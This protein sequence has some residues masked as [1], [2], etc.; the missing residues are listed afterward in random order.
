M[1]CLSGCLVCRAFR[2]EFQFYGNVHSKHRPSK[3][4]KV[5]KM[6]M[7]RQ[8]LQLC[9]SFTSLQKCMLSRLCTL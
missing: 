3:P 5:M 2:E 4:P 9:P 1:R 7:E 8:L 6:H